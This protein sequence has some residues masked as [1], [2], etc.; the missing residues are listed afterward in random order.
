MGRS[1]VAIAAGFFFIMILSFGM[2]AILRVA[3]PDAFDA[4]GRTESAGMLVFSLLYVGVFAF[5]G[6]YIAARLAPSHPMRHALILGGLGLI[7]NIAGSI[8][9]W[10][11]APSWYH[12][13]AIA[14]VMPYAWLGGWLRERQLDRRPSGTAPLAA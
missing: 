14:L 11:T 9:M 12:I 8:A 2:D 6:C 13:I 10:N 5:A 3:V 4:A 7:L 1:I